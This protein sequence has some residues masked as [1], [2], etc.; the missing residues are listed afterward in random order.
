MKPVFDEN[1][2]AITPGDVCCF[3]FDAETGEYTGWSDEYIHVGVSMPENSTD[4]EPGEDMTERVYL[5]NGSGWRQE[6]DYRGKTVYSVENK[7]AS[8]IDYIGPVRDGFVTVAPMSHFDKWDGKKWV[9]DAEA[10]HVADV[11]KAEQQRQSLLNRANQ[12]IAWRQDAV[13]VG[14]ATDEETTALV[15]WKKYRVLLMRVD[16]AKPD[17]P[18]LPGE[19][20]S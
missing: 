9:P 5:F 8:V 13:D 1:R 12:E 19:Q 11:E 14:I 3:Y 4:I 20:A 17:W 6:E 2:L 7:Q 10:Q 16:T 18:T 15:D